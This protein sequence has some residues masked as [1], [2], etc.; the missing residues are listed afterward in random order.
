MNLWKQN[1]PNFSLAFEK[2]TKHSK[3]NRKLRIILLLRTIE[4]WKTQLN[5]RNKIGVITMEF[6]KAFDTLNHNLIVAKLKSY[7]LDLNAVSFIKSYLTNRYQRCK[8]GDSFSEWER[9][10]ARAPK[11]SILGLLLFNIFINYIF[12][13][14]EHSDLCKYADENVLYA[15]GES[16]SIIIE[17]L[18]ADFLRISK[19]F[20]ENVMVLNPDKCY[21]VVLGDS[22]AT[23]NFTCNGTTIE[24]SKEQK[25]LGITI[26]YK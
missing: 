15:S 6:S 9:I 26:D 13:C 22:H 19:W 18:K 3:N 11:G 4:N 25:V 14:F 24:S 17:N 7:G 1:F 16:L 5:K 10:I 20:H 21:F 23:C 8:T 12:L 2:S